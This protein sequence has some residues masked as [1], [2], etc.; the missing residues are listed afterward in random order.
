M[1]VDVK[2]MDD[3]G[4]TWTLEVPGGF[5]I[6]YEVD[7][8]KGFIKSK[9]IPCLLPGAISDTSFF[10]LHEAPTILETWAVTEGGEL[11]GFRR[12]GP[13]IQ[14][15]LLLILNFIRQ[16]HALSSSQSGRQCLV[17]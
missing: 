5:K 3:T 1:G 8:S 10:V 6:F 11:H 2:L 13:T 9:G 14:D 17:M 16:R 7:R 4:E 12:T 15:K